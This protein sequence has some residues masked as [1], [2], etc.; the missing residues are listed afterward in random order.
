MTKNNTLRRWGVGAVAAA[1]VTVPALSALAVEVVPPTP[2]TGSLIE[3]GPVGANGFPT[4]Y[5]DKNADGA[6]SRLEAL[7]A[8][9]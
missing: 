3:V 1:V 2:R 7:P 4:W 6:T 8:P 9:G 5:R